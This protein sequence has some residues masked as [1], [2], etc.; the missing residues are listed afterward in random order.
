MLFAPLTTDRLAL[1]LLQPG[2]AS[3]VF[4]YRSTPEVSRFQSWG[5]ESRDHLESDIRELRQ[6]EP[7]VPGRWCQ[8]GITLLSNHELIGDCGFCVLERDP[9][10][11]EVGIALAPEHRSH[12]YAS[13]ALRCL[14][15]HLLVTQGKHRAF[16]SVDPRNARSIKLLQ[17]VGMRQEAHFRQG[18]WFKGEWVDDLIFAILASEWRQR[19]G[20]PVKNL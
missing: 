20:K 19:V 6:T 18:L 3:R 10:Q 7:G 14:L 13:E 16:G 17:R 9:R 11:V 1:R 4:E 12:G 15:D 2:D 5:T 8:L